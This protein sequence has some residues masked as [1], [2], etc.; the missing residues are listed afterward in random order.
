M[1]PKPKGIFGVIRGTIQS[2]IEDRAPRLAAALSFYTIFAIAPLLVL[3]IGI[4]G[5]IIGND[6]VIRNQI[7]D[8]V[9]Q[10]VGPQGAQIVKTLMT[11]TSLQRQGL[12]A[13]AIGVV[14]VIIGAT[15]IFLQL[16]DSLNT[17][18]EVTPT[19]G[20]GIGGILMER[21]F[22]FAMVL[23]VG[24]LLLVSLVISTALSVLNQYFTHLLGNS[25]PISLMLGYIIQAIVIT[26]VIGAI[27]KTLPDVEIGWGDV[28]VGALVA[29][30][31][32]LAGQYLFSLYLSI[33]S[34]ASI[35][36]AA[37]SLVIILLWVYYSAQI[38][39]FG[40]EFT[41]VYGHWRRPEIVPSENARALTPAERIHQGI[42]RPEDEEQVQQAPSVPGVAAPIPVS[43]PP[44]EQSEVQPNDNEGENI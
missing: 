24:F 18:W 3:V 15:G 41:K 25:V 38:L 8:Q 34:P 31:L 12:L 43:G 44:D 9:Q 21:L 39:F 11:N 42:A 27:Y 37:G 4:T 22:G 23:A 6:A 10:L 1:N 36:G 2:W 40:A 30:I 20:R 17:I 32:F 5:L 19:K 35:Y 29:A 28:W 16:K 33:A 26:L 14:F 13:S 7:L